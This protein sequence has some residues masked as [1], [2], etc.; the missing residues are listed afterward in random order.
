MS[1]GKVN[2]DALLALD[3]TKAGQE[4]VHIAP[5]T[6]VE[7]VLSGI[8]A[9]VLGVGQVGIH[10]NFFE[11]GGHSLKATQLISR[12]RSVFEVDFPLQGLFES[13]TVAKLAETMLRDSG[14]RTRIEE[15][16]EL[17]LKL[18]DLSEDEI[19]TMLAERTNHLS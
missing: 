6:P 13:P 17:L 2:L 10:D 11:L 1:D 7:E 12:L 19:D 15:T 5:R 4:D 16:A 14:E 18:A 8:W 3:Q 9:E